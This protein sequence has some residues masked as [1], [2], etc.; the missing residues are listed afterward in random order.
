MTEFVT[1]VDRQRT[2]LEAEDW[3][4]TPSCIH[5]HSLQSMWYDDRPED[6]ADGQS[7]TDT[8]Y[9]SGLITRTKGGKTIHTWGEAKSGDDLIYAYQH[10]E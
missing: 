1:R 9:N 10:K 4:N 7:V 5:I 2:L 6:T 3:A 8:Q